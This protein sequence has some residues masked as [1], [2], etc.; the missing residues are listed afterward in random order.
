MLLLT[1]INLKFMDD[2]DIRMLKIDSD[3]ASNTDK[4]FS[5]LSIIEEDS[6]AEGVNPAHNELRQIPV[7]KLSLPRQVSIDGAPSLSR[8]LSVS[9][10]EVFLL[11]EEDPSLIVANPS[12]RVLAKARSSQKERK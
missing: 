2:S 1:V 8:Q 10:D 6:D 3:K 11:P 4:L 7:S 9:D 5:G 12:V